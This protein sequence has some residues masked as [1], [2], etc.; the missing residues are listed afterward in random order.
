[1]RLI[2]EFE[3][4]FLIFG[5]FFWNIWIAILVKYKICI[6]IFYFTENYFLVLCKII[7]QFMIKM[8]IKNCYLIINLYYKTCI[9]VIYNIVNIFKNVAEF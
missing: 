7:A 6:I 5:W 8:T 4:I 2:V 1:M 9:H 3:T